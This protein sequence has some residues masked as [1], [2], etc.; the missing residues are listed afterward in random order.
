[1]NQYLL[2]NLLMKP[3]LVSTKNYT[4]TDFKPLF[5]GPVKLALT[6]LSE[7]NIIRSNQLLN[8]KLEKGNTVY[9]VNTGFGNLSHIRIDEK[10]LM[11]LQ[12][13]LARSHA[14]GIGE[15]LE[16]GIVR[17]VFYLKLLTFA[18]GHSGVRIDVA[19]KIIQFI[20]KDILPVMPR[21]GSVGAS[22]DLNP[23]G[24]MTM[25][26]IGEGEVFYKGD[27]V[28]TST[29]L[30]RARLKPLVLYPKEGLSLINGTQISTAIAIKALIDGDNLLK[31][32]DVSGAFSVENS[33]SSKKVFHRE[34]HQLKTHPGQRISAKNVFSALHGSEIVKSHMSRRKLQDP[35]S[36]RCIPH[37]HG[38]CRDSFTSVVKVVNNEINSVSDNPLILHNGNIVNSGHFH[39]EHIAQS[40]DQ[41]SIS[42]TELG[43]ISERRVHYFMKGVSS[44]IPPFV[45]KVPGIESGYMMA[46]VTST[47]LASENKTLSHPASIDSLP[48]SGGQEDL[49]SMAP[50]A[51][52]KVLKIQKNLSVILA[53]ELIV[54]GAANQIASKEKK[55]G[56][57]TVPILKQLM[58][59]CSYD[60]GDRSLEPEI[61][62][63]S[64]QIQSGELLQIITN[65]MKV[66]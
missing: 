61:R 26:L 1:M 2:L 5:C 34:V 50:W 66:E 49:V 59:Y 25:S 33:F 63:V 37:I 18:K 6:K 58:K 35:Y 57:G 27:R 32:A 24:H 53:I 11:R 4:Y 28:D 21:K 19:K 39:A 36:F 23:L 44:L 7:R 55:S 56:K 43:A 16:L 65:Y 60:K 15:P 14:S 42:F 29:A 48:T 8:K 13:N 9:G 54:A 64:K 10:D 20:N 52:Y 62:V 41:L 31:I 40:M 12:I 38:A 51:G 45:A 22:G 46:H 3:L 47:S 17:T 30:R